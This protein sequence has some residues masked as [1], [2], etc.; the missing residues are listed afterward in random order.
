MRTVELQEGV[1]NDELAISIMLPSHVANPLRETTPILAYFLD[2][3]VGLHSS[4]T[5]RELLAPLMSVPEHVLRAPRRRGQAI[6]KKDELKSIKSENPSI[7]IVGK[8]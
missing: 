8:K 4:L 5:P 1:A 2:D 7:L 3:P 6:L